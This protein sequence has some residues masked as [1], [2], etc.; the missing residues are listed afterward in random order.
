MLLRYDPQGAGVFGTRI[1]IGSNPSVDRVWNP[2]AHGADET[3]SRW[4]EAERRFTRTN[5][6]P[7]VRDPGQP[8]V[9][10]PNGRDLLLGESFE[11]VD[12]IAQQIWTTLQELAGVITPFTDDVTKRVEQR[13]RDAHE[14][15]LLALKA[16]YESRLDQMRNAQEAEPSSGRIAPMHTNR[17]N[18]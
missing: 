13:V 2:D 11:R 9:P 5:L 16:E 7:A 3:P 12:E 14:S 4:A 8:T 15:A 6:L 18:M 17:I 10:G 1:D